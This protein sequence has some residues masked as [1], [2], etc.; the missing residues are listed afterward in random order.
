MTQ[1]SRY[2]FIVAAAVLILGVGGG[3]MAY[4]AFRRAAGVPPGVPPEIRFVPADAALVAYADVRALM[5]SEL[6]RELFPSANTGAHKGRQF[7]NDFAGIDV[8]KQVD[9]VVVFLERSDSSAQPAPDSAQP[10]P[11]SFSAPRGIMLV[12]GTFEQARVEQFIRDRQGT[13]ENHNGHAISVHR[14]GQDE[15]AVGFVRTGLLAVGEASLVRR[16]LDLSNDRSGKTQDMTTNTELMNLIRDASGS[17]AWA[18]GHFDAVSRGMRL[19][20]GVSRQVPPLRLVSAKAN[21]NGG[22]KGTIRADTADQASAEQLR[23]MVRG[24]LALARLHG[25]AKSEFEGALK[26]IQLS[27]T[28]NTVQMSFALSSETMR[29]LA[30]YRRYGDLPAPKP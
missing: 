27:G 1:K 17:T 28:G 22:L 3:L 4:L 10:A 13:I 7:M 11:D 12:Q 15:V 16:V 29:A 8:E 26:S 18:V 20:N 9:H 6:R 14:K 5:R 21:V 24:F 23:E 30:P 25:G 19:P 2:F